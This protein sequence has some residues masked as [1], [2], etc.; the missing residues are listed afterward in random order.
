[1]I[2]QTEAELDADWLARREA[3]RAAKAPTLAV[4]ITEIEQTVAML[5]RLAADAEAG[6]IP[7][8]DFMDD[9][10]PG[11]AEVLVPLMMMRYE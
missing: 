9:H 3:I 4:V 7:L 8:T 5:I 6:K 2:A 10:R 11:E 1:M